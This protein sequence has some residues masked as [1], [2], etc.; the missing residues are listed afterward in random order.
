MNIKNGG[1]YTM[2]FQLR[3][4]KALKERNSQSV[5][6]TESGD[7]QLYFYLHNFLDWTQPAVLNCR[8][9]VFHKTDGI[10]VRPMP[11]FFNHEQFRFLED[12]ETFHS[13]YPASKGVSQSKLIKLSECLT[14]NK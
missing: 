11:K 7:Y 8:G 10:V 1:F 14:V 4:F 3:T 6:V 13:F 12:V 2:T 5:G 9:I